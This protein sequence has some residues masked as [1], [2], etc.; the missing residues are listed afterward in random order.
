MD[1]EKGED[2]KSNRRDSDP[3]NAERGVT[4]Y[5]KPLG[6]DKMLIIVFEFCYGVGGLA[7]W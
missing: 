7:E 3:A 2:N 4:Y 1:N 6:L 5:C